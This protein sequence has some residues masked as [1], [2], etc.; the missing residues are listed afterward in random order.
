[1]GERRGIIL[2]CD[3]E[4]V[5]KGE[6]VAHLGLH[7][8]IYA[9]RSR[10]SDVCCCTVVLPRCIVASS[11]AL[12]VYIISSLRQRFQQGRFQQDPAI[13]RTETSYGRRRPG[14]HN[15]WVISVS[16]VMCMATVVWGKYTE[17]SGNTLVAI[18][19]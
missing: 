16:D 6:L 2:A 7:P 14:H 1:M 4:R 10:V 5:W 11:I 8:C 19:S 15:C 3:C 18:R 17:Y 12:C 13:E 9:L